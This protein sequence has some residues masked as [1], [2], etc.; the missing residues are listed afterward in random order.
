MDHVIGVLSFVL[1]KLPN[2]LSTVTGVVAAASTVTALT[3]TPADDRWVGKVY[4]IVEMLALNVG[5]A[6][7]PAGGKAPADR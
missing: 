4:R 2:W 3:P 1:A 6:K 7:D 5:Y